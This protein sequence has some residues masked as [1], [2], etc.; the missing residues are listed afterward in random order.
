MSQ[1][2]V[3]SVASGTTVRVA[4][5]GSPK[6]G[7][8][9]CKRLYVGRF[10]AFDYDAFLKFTP[11]WTNVGKIVSAILTLYTDDGLG[12]VP[13]FVSASDAPKVTFRRLTSAFSEGTANASFVT[14]DYT[15]PSS[16]TTNQRY[17]Q[18][19]ASDVLGVTHIDVTGMVED[20]A[21][22]T[23]LRRNGTP[24]GAL[25]NYGIALL[26]TVDTKQNAGF[27]SEDA[28]A[29]VAAYVPVLTLT[30]EYGLTAPD[31]PTTLSPSGAVA[32]IG[33]FQGDFSDV[34]TSDTLRTSEVEVYTNPVAGTAAITDIITSSAH[35][36]ANGAVVYFPSLTGGTGLSTFTPYYVRDR[37]T[38]TFKVA[39]TSGGAAVNITVAYSALTWAKRVYDVTQAE[40]NTAILAARF[41][42]VPS[43]L[44]ILTNV[45]YQWRARVTDQEGQT[46]PWTA[47]VSFSVTNTNPDAPTLTPVDGSTY[48]SLD[49]IQFRGGTFSDPDIG[50]TLLAYQVQLSAYPSGDAHWL[51]D[52]YILWNTGKFYV[53]SGS[54]DWQTPYGGAALS[55][56]TY[57]W[58]ARQWDNHQGVSA[59]TYASIVLTAD[60]IVEAS[61]STNAIQLRPRAAWRIVIRDMGTLRGPGAVVAI[62]EDAY[63]VGASILYNSPGE[64]HWTLGIA[65]P[66]LSVIEPK[67]THYA[68]EFRQGDGWREVFAGLVWD[69]DA[70]DR[71][72]VFYGV[73]YLGLLDFM[74]DEHYDPA[75]IEKAASLGG[76]KYSNYTIRNII[77]DQLKRAREL[78]NSPV[79][80]ITTG[81]IGTMSETVTVYSTYQPTLNFVVG[82][83][84]SHRAGSGKRTRLSVN[85]TTAGGYEFV[86]KDDPG[87]QR[88]NLRLRYGELVQG[89]RVI[90]FGNTWASRINAVGR[91]KDGLKVRYQSLTAPGIDESVWGRFA[92]QQ[93]FDNISDANDME[94]RTRQAAIAASKLGHQVALGLRSG[95]L[96]PR[97]GYDLC[98]QFPVDIV[99]GSVD[100]GNFGSGYWVA[101]GI[102]WQA[103]QRGDL[104]TTLTLQPREDSTPPSSDL[105]TLQPISSQAEWQI[106][107]TPPT[108]VTP[109]SKY[110]LDQSTGKVYIRVDGALIFTGITGDV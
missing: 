25:T 70:S 102:T 101:V 68:I 8:G 92:S 34:K 77:I 53:G 74:A 80:F 21:P 89:Y 41:D 17:Q 51:D 81:A 90:P 106:G 61:D 3:W 5:D 59:W 10:S 43:S 65:H 12:V 64:A 24:G 9:N 14:A 28:E 66:Q 104:D 44:T 109:T 7:A 55:A 93:F 57:Y 98:D 27:I 35:G 52:N 2:L 83:I 54:T 91:D 63:N 50:D 23:V 48:A 108:V 39:A 62:L 46:S 103:L 49:G 16:T 60:F 75:N 87:V 82:L 37:T 1:T 85:K 110:W 20:I 86:I 84:D 13:D 99:H 22:K 76:S 56:G 15:A 36:L 38:N 97:D 105:L 96:Q 42:H 32:A 26:G 40:S 94:R 69:F 58:R 71:D 73:D 47:L 33:S 4:T 95:V 100:T 107:W 72:V 31:V 88:D 79:G 11:V 18:A 29:G 78:A 67:Q 19:C 30:F 45:T 6:Q